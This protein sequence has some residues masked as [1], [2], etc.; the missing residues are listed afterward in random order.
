MEDNRARGS[1]SIHP[2]R[3]FEHK[4]FLFIC[5]LACFYVGERCV[6]MNAA[7][8]LCGGQRTTFRSQISPPACGFQG[9]RQVVRL[10][11]KSLSH[12][13]FSTL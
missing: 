13:A 6:N 3:A 4:C 10:A 2:A 5:L 11:D 9:Q 7:Q 1:T 12:S 8:I